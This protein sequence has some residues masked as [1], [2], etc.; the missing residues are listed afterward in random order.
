MPGGEVFSMAK[1]GS[2]AHLW[3]WGVGPIPLKQDEVQ[4]F[5]RGALPPKEN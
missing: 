5:Q 2:Y 4:V 3:N 1:S